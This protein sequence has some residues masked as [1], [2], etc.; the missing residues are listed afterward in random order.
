VAAL[1]SS[2]QVRKAELDT[3]VDAGVVRGCIREAV[4]RACS[5]DGGWVIRGRYGEGHFV[6]PKEKSKHTGYGASDVV[7]PGRVLR[8][9]RIILQ[10]L[11]VWVG[12]R[13]RIS[14]AVLASAKRRAL[15][16]MLY[17]CATAMSRKARYQSTR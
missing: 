5:L 7:G 11:P 10:W 13:I 12:L 4:I 9:V 6:G 14:V 15:S 8:I 16:S 1:P 3:S 17:T 2:L